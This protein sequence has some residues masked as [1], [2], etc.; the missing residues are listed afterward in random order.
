MRDDTRVV[1]PLPVGLDTGDGGFAR[2]VRGRLG[3][4]SLGVALGLAVSEALEDLDLL[5]RSEVALV[6]LQPPVLRK[7]TYR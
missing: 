4:V 6:F 7:R 5:C 3:D 2:L 1:E